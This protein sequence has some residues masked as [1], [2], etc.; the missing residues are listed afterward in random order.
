MGREFFPSSSVKVMEAY[1]TAIQTANAKTGFL[2]PT[3]CISQ[4]VLYL[5]HMGVI[6][7]YIVFYIKS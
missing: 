7:K 2:E 5:K 4:Y 3:N 1:A 6:P